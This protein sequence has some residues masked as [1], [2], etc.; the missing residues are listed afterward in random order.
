MVN[1]LKKTELKKTELKTV[2]FDQRRFPA[3]LKEL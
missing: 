2:L 3:F 1:E